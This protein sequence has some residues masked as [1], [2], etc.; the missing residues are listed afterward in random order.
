MSCDRAKDLLQLYLDGALDLSEA[1]EVE[2]H[3]AGCVACRTDFVRMERLF[4]AMEALPRVEAPG[5]LLPRTMAAIARRA[6]WLDSPAAQWLVNAGGV[7]AMVSGLALAAMSAEEASSAF[8][9]LLMDQ[10]E[11]VALVDGL[12]AIAASLEFTLVA[13]IALLLGAGCLTLIHLV[14]TP[15]TEV[16]TG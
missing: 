2:A 14:S 10:G 13:G 3:V 15:S 4:I 6:P 1:R 5:Q 12:L 7:V 11:P 8:A 9:A 16:R